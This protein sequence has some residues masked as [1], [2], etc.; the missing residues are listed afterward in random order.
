MEINKTAIVASRWFSILLFSIL[1]FSI[2]LLLDVI[3]PVFLRRKY[4]Y[5]TLKYVTTTSSEVI[6]TLHFNNR[7]TCHAIAVVNFGSAFKK[8]G[9]NMH[10]ALKSPPLPPHV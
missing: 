4:L 7:L 10:I 5:S 2:L 9:S 6:L 3:I 1:L 8:R